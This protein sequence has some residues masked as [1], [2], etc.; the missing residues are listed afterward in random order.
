MSQQSILW[1]NVD[2]FITCIKIS[3]KN[4]SIMRLGLLHSPWTYQVLFTL[5]PTSL[6]VQPTFFVGL[7]FPKCPKHWKCNLL[8][9]F[10]RMDTFAISTFASNKQ[11]L[12][13]KFNIIYIISIVVVIILQGCSWYHFMQWYHWS[14][15]TGSHF[16][17]FDKPLD[18]LLKLNYL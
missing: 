1:V 4:W 18:R 14:S 10:D 12:I 17:V 7:K 2:L 16:Q 5:Q 9:A 3:F 11:I 13:F 15:G 8:A 6:H